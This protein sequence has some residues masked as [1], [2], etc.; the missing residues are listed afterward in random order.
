MS[1]RS[2]ASDG[3]MR[4][5][6]EHIK[7]NFC[8]NWIAQLEK[9]DDV[10]LALRKVG[11]YASSLAVPPTLHTRFLTANSVSTEEVVCCGLK[12]VLTKKLNDIDL[13]LRKHSSER[14]T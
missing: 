6:R 12:R 7:D 11:G 8:D 13:Y 2:L 5:D 3:S 14:K 4:C 10:S 9:E 1:D